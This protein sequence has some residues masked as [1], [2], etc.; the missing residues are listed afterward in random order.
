MLCRQCWLFN[1]KEVSVVDAHCVQRVLL[2]AGDG[3]AGH[4]HLP[5]LRTRSSKIRSVALS[6]CTTELLP[7]RQ[8]LS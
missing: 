1:E 4:L 5:H 3:H 2:Q 8:Q 6:C 7:W